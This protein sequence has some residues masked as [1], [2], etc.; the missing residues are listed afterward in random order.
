PPDLTGGCPRGL[1]ARRLLRRVERAVA[2]PGARTST[3]PGRAPD[4]AAD[5]LRAAVLHLPLRH[6][7]GACPAGGPVCSHGRRLP[8]LATRLQLLRRGVGWLHRVIRYGCPDRRGDGHLP[9]G[10][11][12]PEAAANERL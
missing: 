9:G 2:E 1:A 8:A 5:H 6:R 3:A 12:R 4:R 11:R 10:S 7:G